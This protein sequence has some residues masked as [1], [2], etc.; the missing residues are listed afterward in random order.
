MNWQLNHFFS[1]TIFTFFIYTGVQ[2]QIGKVGVNTTTPLAA[3]HVLDSSVL[4]SGATTLPGIIHQGPPPVSGQGIRMMW[5]PDRAA[6]RAG[7]TAGDHWDKSNVGDFSFAAGF[8][9]KAS[10]FISIA[11]G[12]SAYAE[13]NYAVA[14]GLL[15]KASGHISTAF[16]NRTVANG[17]SSVAFGNYSV[18]NGQSSTAMGFDTRAD[19]MGSVSSGENTVANGRSSTAFGFGTRASGAHSTSLGFHTIANG[20]AS[21]T[22]GSHNDSLIAPEM[23]PTATSPVFII[24]NGTNNF[25]KSNVMVVRRNGRVGI[26]ENFPAARLHV[27]DSSVL[28][29]GQYTV[30]SDPPPVSGAGSR[31]MWYPSRAAFRSG[32]V[33]GAQWDHGNVGLFSVAAG[34]NAVASSNSTVALGEGTLAIGGNSV[35]IGLQS[36]ASGTA[37]V[38]L[39]WGVT[40]ANQASMAFGRS[41]EAFGFSSTAFGYQTIAS[42]SY[43]T[44][45]GY[46]TVASGTFSTA[47]GR[48][49]TASG[50]SSTAFGHNT[51]AAGDNSTAMGLSTE[52]SGIHSFSAGNTTLAKGG[53]SVALGRITQ[54]NGYGSL[55][56]GEYNDTLVAPQNVT[57]STTPLFIIGNG[58]STVNRTNAMIVRKDGRVG[59]GTNTPDNR[60][61]ISSDGTSDNAEIVLGLI[62]NVSNRPVLQF[63]ENTVAIPTSGMSIEYNGTGGG[64]DNKLH[65]RG[66]DAVRRVT[67]M[68]NGRLGIGTETP[69]RELS[70]FDIGA[71]GD[72]LISLETST[73]GAKEMI[74]GVN[75]STG[76]LFGMVTNTN[77]TF[78][79]NNTTRMTITGAGNV[80]IG[81]SSPVELLHIGTGTGAS[82]RLGSIETLEDAGGNT[83]SS[84]STLIPANDNNYDLG[85]SGNRWQDVW[86][87][88]GVI[89]TS[90]ARDKT[91]IVPLE[92]SLEKIQHLQPVRYRWKDEFNPGS[93]IG[94][95]A[96]DV[97]KIIPEAVRSTD[98]IVNE[99]GTYTEINTERLGLNYSMIV[100]VLIKAVQEQQEMINQQAEQ[101]NQQQVLINDLV[102][103]MERLESQ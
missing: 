101:L 73:G 60:V 84:N 82:I 74:A 76:G 49:T 93:Q 4:F 23:T 19:G 44:S 26:G 78:R 18:A 24:G 96:Q 89:Q 87:T 51:L 62:S 34:Y 7:Y 47:G 88:N 64:S 68:N 27:Q 13:G 11:L 69:V 48:S 21:L 92:E 83:I 97:E 16:G 58:S 80:G 2:A 17:N 20:Y 95:L 56:I 3:F 43:A 37:S 99:D 81:N 79:T 98:L 22:I 36:E 55:V 54:A 25:T 90:D 71:N 102:K 72:A 29:S 52:A 30:P 10:G 75:Q 1:L 103:R 6:F 35:A 12:D 15:T 86:A 50:S 42:N 66:T 40:A 9:P 100:P 39:G 61:D 65:I 46:Q 63:S 45:F 59:I 14:L 67:I 70:I 31:M 41:T 53:A 94:L 57:T 8:G 91:D 85:S 33:T 38:A 77:L 5:Y 28:F 32:H